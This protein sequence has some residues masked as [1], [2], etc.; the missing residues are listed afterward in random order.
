MAWLRT[1]APK[2]MWAPTLE[3]V[4][5]PRTEEFSLIVNGYFQSSRKYYS[6]FLTVMDKWHLSRIRARLI[7]LFQNLET[8]PEQVLANLPVG[9][10]T[11]SD[12]HK[13]VR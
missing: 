6:A 10:R 3:V 4:C 5:I 13:F 9:D 7:A 2:S 12:F 11:F 1:H 8:S